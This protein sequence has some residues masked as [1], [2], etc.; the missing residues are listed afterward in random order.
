MVWS[1]IRWAVFGC[2]AV[3]P[4]KGGVVLDIHPVLGDAI[5]KGLIAGVILRQYSLCFTVAVAV[6]HI[7]Q[8]I[9]GFADALD[10]AAKRDGVGV[11]VK[12]QRGF[13]ADDL[14][15][16]FCARF[17]V[18]VFRYREPE[19]YRLG[20]AAK[21][22]VGES[23]GVSLPVVGF[24]REGGYQLRGIGFADGVAQDKK[25]GQCKQQG[26]GCPAG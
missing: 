9:R 18:G 24:Q 21:V 25:G 1:V 20:R 26:K 5:E 23:G 7:R 8:E 12:V 14:P 3:I 10:G 15:Q 2:K 4:V 19:T 16:G 22:V 6:V 11:A 13:L 17:G